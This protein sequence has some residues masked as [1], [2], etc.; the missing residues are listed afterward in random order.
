MRDY[1]SSKSKVAQIKEM[2]LDSNYLYERGLYD[3][4]EERLEDAKALAVEMDEQLELLEIN[5]KQR[6]LIWNGIKTDFKDQLE[7]LSKENERSLSFIKE[8]YEYLGIYE[9]LFSEVLRNPSKPDERK[10]N[11]LSKFEDKFRNED[12]CPQSAHAKRKYYQC[13]GLYFELQRNSKMVY[14]YYSKVIDWWEEHPKLKSEEYFRYVIDISNLLFFCLQME[15]YED[16]KR[17]IKLIEENPPVNQHDQKVVFKRLSVCKVYYHLNSKEKEGT[18]DL[19]QEIEEGL[20][21]YDIGISNKFSLIGNVAFLLFIQKDYDGARKWSSEIVR[22]KQIDFRKDVQIA[23]NILF[24]ISTVEMDDLDEIDAA[25]RLINRNFS[26]KYKSFIGVFE[27]L[28]VE[29][30]K[31]VNQQIS[32]KD[33]TSALQNFRAEIIAFKESEN[34]KASFQLDDLVIQW[35]DYKIPN[36]KIVVG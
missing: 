14:H 25:F 2:I 18:E 28:I 4:C 26:Q 34:N 16:F 35:I 19:I 6:S 10:K 15:K 33:K 8:E 36:K 32:Q 27:N 21:K 5:K 20:R 29:N 30:L 31:K 17:Y 1:R 9:I 13:A 3:Q 22:E 24:L 11:L 7:T 12:S 23:M